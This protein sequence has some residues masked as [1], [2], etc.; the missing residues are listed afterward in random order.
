M[1]KRGEFH[2]SVLFTI[3][4]VIKKETIFENFMILVIGK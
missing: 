2:F 1:V 4:T 3:I